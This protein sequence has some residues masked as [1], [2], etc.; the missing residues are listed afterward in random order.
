MLI[1]ISHVAGHYH[2][3]LFRSAADQQLH[4]IGILGMIP[5]HFAARHDVV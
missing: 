4:A 1:G 3:P 2:I 5:H